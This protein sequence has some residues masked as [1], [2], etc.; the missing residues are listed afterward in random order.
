MIY[1]GHETR[2]DALLG[3]AA[4]GGHFKNNGDPGWLVL[5][6][7]FSRFIEAETVWRLVRP[8]M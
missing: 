2:K 4:L 7:G 5:G 6:R 1:M 8:R 3:I